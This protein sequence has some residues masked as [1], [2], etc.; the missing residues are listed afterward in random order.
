MEGN[1]ATSPLRK[2][3]TPP[4]LKASTKTRYVVKRNTAKFPTG[5]KRFYNSRR[6]FPAG[7]KLVSEARR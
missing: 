5:R 4:T 6:Q 1:F 2:T 7:R 3:A